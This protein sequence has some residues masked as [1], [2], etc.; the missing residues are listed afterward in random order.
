MYDLFFIVD[1]TTSDTNFTKLKERFPLA[2]KVSSFAEAQRKAFTKF[3]WVVWQDLSINDSFNFDYEV[4]EWDK[5]YIHVFK[6]KDLYDGVCLFPKAAK[7]SEREV[8][9]RFF[10]NKK[11]VDIVA[12]V[13]APFDVVFIS[14][15]ESNA[16]EN[17]NELLKRIPNAKRVHGVKGI[18]QA[19]IK[20]AEL[21]TT[22]MFWVV[23]A[24]AK[25]LDTFNFEH[26]VPAHN[27]NSVFVWRSRN[28]INNLEYGYGGVKLLPKDLT[29]KLNTSSADMTTSIS[30]KFCAVDQVSNITVFNTDEFNTWKSAFREC[31][32]LSS[33]VIDGQVSSETEQRLAVWCNENNGAPYGN[34]AIAGAIAGQKYGQENAAN[35][36]ALSLINDFDWLKKQ[37]QETR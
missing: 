15:N 36:A 35:L 19:H 13:P 18:H 1:S 22:P 28:P 17:Y 20:A 30:S 25:I 27:Y 2:R 21:V 8:K 4:S 31:V 26:Q 5:Q 34:Y 11:E 16:D 3:F 32:K 10:V 7:V 24:D 29:L 23:D 9:Y 37:F 33:K 14:Y 6:N 12:S